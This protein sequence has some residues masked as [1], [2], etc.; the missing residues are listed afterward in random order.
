MGPP[1]DVEAWH[2]VIN[3]IC[4]NAAAHRQQ[5]CC[6]VL[7]LPSRIVR[8]QVKPTGVPLPKKKKREENNMGRFWREERSMAG[9]HPAW[10]LCGL[11]VAVDGF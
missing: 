8:W 10:W 1:A 11:Q 4:K 3:G 5:D 7:C 6:V 2:L 9:T